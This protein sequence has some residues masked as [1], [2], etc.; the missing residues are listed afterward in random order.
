MMQDSLLM[1]FGYIVASILF[2]WG[3][4][5]LSKADTARQGNMV[6]AVGMLVAILSSVMI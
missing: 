2:I 5:M 1:D 4:K 6:S 3:I